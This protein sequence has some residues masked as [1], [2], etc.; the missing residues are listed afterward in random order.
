MKGNI[1][2]ISRAADNETL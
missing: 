2:T 1:N